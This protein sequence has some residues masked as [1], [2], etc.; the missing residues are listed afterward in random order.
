MPSFLH[1]CF[2]FS[3]GR[4]PC[5]ILYATNQSPW[6]LKRVESSHGLASVHGGCT[7]YTRRDLASRGCYGLWSGAADLFFSYPVRSRAILNILG[8]F[9]YRDLYLGR[10]HVSPVLHRPLPERLILSLGAFP[11]NRYPGSFSF[12]STMY[13]PDAEVELTLQRMLPWIYFIFFRLPCIHVLIFTKV[14][15]VRMHMTDRSAAFGPFAYE[16]QPHKMRAFCFFHWPL[17]VGRS[18]GHRRAGVG[19]GLDADGLRHSGSCRGFEQSTPEQKWQTELSRTEQRMADKAQKFNLPPYAIWSKF[20][21]DL[22]K[23][24]WADLSR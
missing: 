12:V 15:H 21:P 7:R 6:A 9:A 24:G 20:C 16:E 1:R 3:R 18:D 4:R 17:G 11:P 19:V 5:P 13:I 22:P 2:L 14:T 8:P 10:P 23:F